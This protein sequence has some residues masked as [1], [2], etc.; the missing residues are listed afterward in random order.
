MS[1]KQNLKKALGNVTCVPT[2]MTWLHPIMMLL[3]FSNS[4]SLLLMPFFEPTVWQFYLPGPVAH[5]IEPTELETVTFFST[6]PAQTNLQSPLKGMNITH[7]H[8]FTRC[9]L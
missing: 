4:F 7:H 3:S 5:S 2:W 9:H 6:G 8:L 1:L